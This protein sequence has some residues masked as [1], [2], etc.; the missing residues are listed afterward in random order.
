MLPE[1]EEMLKGHFL[2][3][4]EVTGCRKLNACRQV[5]VE[6]RTV[7]KWQEADPDFALRMMELHLG[8]LEELRAV[9]IEAARNPEKGFLSRIT[10]LKRLDPSYRERQ[11]EIPVSGPVQINI[12][13]KAQEL[14]QGAIVDAEVK[15]LPSG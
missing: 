3:A 8:L 1:Q 10:E 14:P 11:W 4:Y 12:V 13:Y 6:P 5:H 9:N 7:D 2:R 15:E